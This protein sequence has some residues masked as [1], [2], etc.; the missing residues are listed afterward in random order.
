MKHLI[1][2]AL[3]VSLFACSGPAFTVASAESQLSQPTTPEA[4]DFPPVDA[5]T[6]RP[7]AG[8]AEVAADAGTALPDAATS[9]PDAGQALPDAGP[10]PAEAAAVEAAPVE[11]ST[12]PALQCTSTMDAEGFVF[13][14]GSLNFGDVAVGQSVTW[15]ITVDNRGTCYAAVSSPK[16]QWGEYSSS[17]DCG[18]LDPGK[19]C[20][21]E[22]TFA[23]TLLGRAESQG[24]V[25]ILG[26][27]YTYSVVGLGEPTSP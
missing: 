6:S 9:L 19:S 10:A 12:S 4:T 17:S 7:D 3:S 16:A 2:I 5:P 27:T 24:T 14:T 20:T 13:S 18:V 11:A 21:I 8:A 15:P 1:I 22:V 23:P 26:Q 25:T